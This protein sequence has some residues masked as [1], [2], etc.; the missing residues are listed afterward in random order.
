MFL[1]LESRSTEAE[2]SSV[3]DIV[4]NAANGALVGEKKGK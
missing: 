4:R 1:F 3:P 2:I